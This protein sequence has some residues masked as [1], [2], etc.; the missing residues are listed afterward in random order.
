MYYVIAVC[1]SVGDPHYKTFDGKEFSFMGVCQYVLV[2]DV[3]NSFSVTVQNVPCGTTGV[4]CTKSLVIEVGGYSVEL[5]QVSG[6]HVLCP[7]GVG[8][9][10]GGSPP[11]MDQCRYGGW[12]GEGGGAPLMDQCMYSGGGGSSPYGPV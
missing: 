3:E 2:R 11:H 6:L 7:R 12:V 9:G 1:Y 5:V 4:T 8:W 10:G